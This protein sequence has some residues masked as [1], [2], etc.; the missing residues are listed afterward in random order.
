MP[1]ITDPT[2]TTFPAANWPK[3]NYA[4]IPVGSSSRNW[5][6]DADVGVVTGALLDVRSWVNS[7]SGGIAS[8]SSSFVVVS[9]SYA[10][11]SATFVLTSSDFRRVSSSFVTLSGSFVSLGTSYNASQVAFTAL[12]NSYLAVSASYVAFSQSSNVAALSGILAGVSST[13]SSRINAGGT[14]TFNFL[15]VNFGRVANVAAPSASTDAANKNYVDT[16]SN[17]LTGLP[18]LINGSG[19]APPGAIRVTALPTPW[20]LSGSLLMTFSGSIEAS[21]S[22]ILRSP[23]GGRWALNVDAT[24]AL[25]TTL[26]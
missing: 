19:S 23:T 20:V 2:G 1:F 16:Q 25:F 13:V 21:S 15:D 8:V 26:L 4:P 9:S 17:P 18:V 3:S 11:L 22:F 14:G 5:W 7:V 12:S 10:A 24:G 6:Q